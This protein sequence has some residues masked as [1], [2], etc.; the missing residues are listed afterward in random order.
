MCSL[1]NSS[2]DSELQRSE[3][4][5]VVLTLKGLGVEDP[6]CFDWLVSHE[7]NGKENLENLVGRF[8]DAFSTLFALGAL[9]EK[10][11]LTKKGWDLL[12]IPLP[13]TVACLIL[14]AV[15]YHRQHH[16]QQ[17]QQQ[18]QQQ[19]QQNAQQVLSKMITCCAIVGSEVDLFITPPQPN[20]SFSLKSSHSPSANNKSS[21]KNHRIRAE[22][23]K[24]ENQKVQR[25]YDKAKQSHSRFKSNESD[26][27]TTTNCFDAWVRES[28]LEQQNAT[29]GKKQKRNR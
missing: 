15:E 21:K 24:A 27:I 19:R 28:F 1:T 25:E 13:V 11:L 9:D 26:L 3:L 10:M 8:R 18:Q 6:R 2:L 7:K 17:Q 23:Q 20:Q 5:S 4:T 29:G 22:Q 16:Q 12:R 14:E